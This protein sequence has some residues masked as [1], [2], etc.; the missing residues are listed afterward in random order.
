VFDGHG[1]REVAAYT[2]KHY[3]SFL[4][5]SEGYKNAN[6]ETALKQSFHKVDEELEKEPGKE[7]LA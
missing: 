7:E 2:E 1:G 3:P 5:E 6:M 4:K